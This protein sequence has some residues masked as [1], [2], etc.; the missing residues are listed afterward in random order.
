MI[1][2]HELST[3]KSRQAIVFHQSKAKFHETIVASETQLLFQLE[4]EVA[5]LRALLDASGHAASIATLQD[6]LYPTADISPDVPS[7]HTF[8]CQSSNW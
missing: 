3:V 4:Q 7:G 6:V 5:N 1:E 2:Q 8:A